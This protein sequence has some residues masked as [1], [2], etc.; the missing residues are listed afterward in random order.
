MRVN[1]LRGDLVHN[2]LN[3][4]R[5]PF[6]VRAQCACRFRLRTDKRHARQT[7]THTHT[8]TQTDRQFE[9]YILGELRIDINLI[10]YIILQNNNFWS[11]INNLDKVLLNLVAFAFFHILHVTSFVFVMMAICSSIKRITIYS[12][13][14]VFCISYSRM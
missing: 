2:F 10:F 8:H 6:P 12:R 11:L 9:L 5:K 13:I 1:P 14:F 7:R 4:L 3:F